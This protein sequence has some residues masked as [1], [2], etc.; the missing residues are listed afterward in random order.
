MRLHELA[1]EL[2]NE[3]KTT[4]LRFLSTNRS[5]DAYHQGIVLIG[6]DEAFGGDVRRQLRRA[7]LGR[8]R[9]QKKFV[10]IEAQYSL[11]RAYFFELIRRTE[12]EAE[13]RGEDPQDYWRGN[14]D[15]LTPFGP[16]S[17]RR[18]AATIASRRISE[19][20]VSF[21]RSIG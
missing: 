9:K 5:Q 3:D 21:K 15:T 11:I 14:F 16:Y 18:L 19:M 1:D 6:F 7:S 4:Q 8:F 2:N 13:L 20:R 12:S 17:L 10:A